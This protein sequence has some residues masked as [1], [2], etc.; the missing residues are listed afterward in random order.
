MVQPLRLLLVEDSEVDAELLF[1]QLNRVGYQV[2]C[3]RVETAPEF[4][5]ALADQEWDLIIADYHLP[6]FNA[7]EALRIYQASGLDLPFLIVSGTVGEETA[8]AAMKAGA[9]DYLMKDNLKRLGPAIARELREFQERSK[10]R[11]AEAA[12]QDLQNEQEMRKLKASFFSMLSHELKNPLGAMKTATDLL[13]NHR[14]KLSA[15]KVEQYFQTIRSGIEQINQLLND[16][17]MIGK[18]ESGRLE[19][20]P[21]PLNVEWFCQELIE[22]VQLSFGLGHFIQLRVHDLRSNPMQTLET[23]PPDGATGTDV[24]QWLA[25]HP[26]YC[27]LDGDLLRH[28]LLNLLSNAIKYSP[29]ATPILIDLIYSPD[30]TS[31]TYASLMA[32]IA[33]MNATLDTTFNPSDPHPAYSPTNGLGVAAT[34]DSI[35]PMPL[36]EGHWLDGTGQGDAAGTLDAIEN[37]F[38]ATTCLGETIS[39]TSGMNGEPIAPPPPTDLSRPLTMANFGAVERGADGR[40]PTQSSNGWITI[41]IQ[42]RGIG[43]PPEAVTKLFD[44]F[45]RAQNVGEIPGTGLGLTIVKQCVELHGGQVTVESTLGVGTVFIVLLPFSSGS[46]PT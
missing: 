33:S 44:S 18:V 13:E 10:R 6:Q 46:S 20:Q 24:V 30:L 19:F 28:I 43:I 37:P 23:R 14:D 29:E 5:H 3:R 39:P 15:E 26:C 22:S 36:L 12:L 27:L 21:A 32:D 41:R 16:L 9:H 4:L 42:D 11:T 2:D 7:L 17:L 25:N 38:R 35:N 40:S 31:P 1:L 45:Y 34:N 8:V